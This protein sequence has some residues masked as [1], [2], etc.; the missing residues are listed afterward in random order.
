M[1]NF[2]RNGDFLEWPNG[3]SIPIAPGTATTAIS[4]D[5]TF[6]KTGSPV[7]TITISRQQ[8]PVLTSIRQGFPTYFLRVTPSFGVTLGA[9]DKSYL[10]W[11]FVETLDRH[12][13]QGAYSHLTFWAKSGVDREI[14]VRFVRTFGAGGS[15]NN[16]HTSEVLVTKS[17]QLTKGWR[18]YQVDCRF[19]AFPATY[20]TGA[21]VEARIY[22]QGGSSELGADVIP[23]WPNA[24]VDF[25]QVALTLTQIAEDYATNRLSLGSPALERIPLYV[26]V[27]DFG[28]IGDGVTDDTAAVVRAYNA[29]S[30]ILGGEIRFGP[31]IWKYNLVLAKN[32]VTITGQCHY[33]DGF[34]AT[35]NMRNRHIPADITKPVIQVGDDA[36]YYRGI[37][38]RECNFYG[39]DTGSTGLYLAGG[40][41]ECSVQNCVVTSSL[42]ALK[43]RAEQISPRQLSDSQML[44]VSRRTSSARVA[45]ISRTR[46]IIRPLGRRKST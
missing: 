42:P 3:S 16:G 9:S 46:R 12:V 29:L 2:I 38:I 30:P 32:N 10:S 25:S 20:G 18:K 7:P 36:N 1:N 24:S 39:A 21:T 43:C 31:G 5:L 14:V 4:G 34:A 19:P 13:A 8:H 41:F 33:R 35:V 23:S 45:G 22:L 44:T 6:V 26:D 17:V 37:I 15:N 28:A 11:T 27:A 40:A